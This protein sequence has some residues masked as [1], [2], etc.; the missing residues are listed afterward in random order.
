MI[1][2]KVNLFILEIL[3]VIII[4]I[5]FFHLLSFKA[6]PNDD[7]QTSKIE[8]QLSEIKSKNQNTYIGI[9]KS[10]LGM[11]KKNGVGWTISFSEYALK[12]N[13]ITFDQCHNLLHLIGHQA[14]ENYKNDFDR[15]AKYDSTFC[16]AS[17]EHG[18]EAQIAI[19]GVNDTKNLEDYCTALRKVTPG[20]SC[21]HGAGHGYMSVLK[22]PYKAVQKCDLLEGG[23]DEG[24]W[25]CY[26]GVFSEY[27]NQA[28]GFDSDTGIKIS[29]KPMVPLD[30]KNPY[31]FCDTFDAKYQDSCY[32]QLTK[33]LITGTLDD[34][35]K[36]CLN[37]S[38]TPHQQ[39]ICVN[40]IAGV[41]S[42]SN[43]SGSDN[44]ELAVL[45]PTLSDNLQKAYIQGIRETFF[46]YSQSRIQ[47]D[48]QKFCKIL[49]A[50]KDYCLSIY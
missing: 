43:L 30:F 47:K 5:V 44:V 42:R 22:N 48:W 45:F 27:G 38:Y 7:N 13:D 23:P 26:R 9:L 37:P 15:L 36:N 8:N 24:L 41:M 33:V 18:V 21:Y 31:K 34:S 49:P 20:L 39:E 14:Y 2:K 16:I 28:L 3:A 17:F 40:I 50:Q 19:D 25:N 6:P 11:I 10:L 46:G 1:K 4:E 35:L 29:D 32:S 12:R